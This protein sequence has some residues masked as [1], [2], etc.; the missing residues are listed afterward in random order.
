MQQ[1]LNRRLRHAMR[2]IFG[3]WMALFAMASQTP[4]RKRCPA[5]ATVS[6]T[7][8][9]TSA[10]GKLKTVQQSKR[11]APPHNPPPPTLSLGFLRL[12]GF[13]HIPPRVKS[14]GRGERQRRQRRQ[15][16]RRPSGHTL[17]RARRDRGVAPRRRDLGFPKQLLS[18]SSSFENGNL[19]EQ[20]ELGQKPT[21]LATTPVRGYA[22]L[23]N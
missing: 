4:T 15:G 10:R 20:G 21:G 12:V 22:D 5:R 14:E 9:Q 18:S 16:Q 7:P 1:V 2:R 19:Q 6:T 13:G 23:E 17:E 8:L 3:E 11:K